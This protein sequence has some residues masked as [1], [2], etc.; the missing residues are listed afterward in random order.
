MAKVTSRQELKDWCLRKLGWP[1][2]EINVDDDQV[3][4]R[5][6]EAFS[7]YFDYHYD[8][9]ERLFYGHQITQTDIDNGYIE[10]P[11]SLIHITRV[12]P[13]GGSMGAGMFYPMGD[14]SLAWNSTSS[15]PLQGMGANASNGVPMR[16]VEDHGGA[17]S[18]GM[19]NKVSFY[20]AMQSIEEFSQI[21]VVG[22]PPMRFS[23]HT[24]RVY[25]D[26]EWAT[27]MQ[28]DGYLVAEGWA[29]LDPEV[30]TDVYND[31]WLKSYATQLIKQQWGAN[32]IKYSGVQLPGGV[33]FDG[34]K[35]YEQASAAIEKLEEEMQLKYELPVDFY[36]G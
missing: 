19:S 18:G 17:G 29:S 23:R 35:L 25:L 15:N 21:F 11:D 12:L 36:M 5:I 24:N 2:I 33:T 10:V 32:L 13:M 22:E 26:L 14:P 9:V 20:L 30:Y 27:K 6:D 34:D 31:R 7:F 16:T 28:V 4:D 8:A 1:V 3:D